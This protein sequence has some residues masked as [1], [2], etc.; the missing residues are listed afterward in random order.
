MEINFKIFVKNLNKF[1]YFELNNGKD[2]L[3][4]NDKIMNDIK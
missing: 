1:T 4:K 3:F 2:F